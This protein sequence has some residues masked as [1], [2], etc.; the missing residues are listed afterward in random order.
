MS[1]LSAGIICLEQFL[2]TL[3]QKHIPQST[4]QKP[5]NQKIANFQGFP[6]LCTSVL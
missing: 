1:K 4:Q 2:I 5:T 3:N 6:P